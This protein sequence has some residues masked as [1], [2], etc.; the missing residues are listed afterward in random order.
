MDEA[1]CGLNVLV[2][3]VRNTI[4]NS[5]GHYTLADTV[6]ITLRKMR[7][8]RMPIPFV[9][10]IHLPVQMTQCS[11]PGQDDRSKK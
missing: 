3:E 8:D 7:R 11:R 9:G 2:L 6:E 5:P 1:H 4:A 10:V